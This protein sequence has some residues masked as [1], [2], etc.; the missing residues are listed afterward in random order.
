MVLRVQ[1]ISRRS[2]LLYTNVTVDL[3]S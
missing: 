1:V 3:L 2:Q